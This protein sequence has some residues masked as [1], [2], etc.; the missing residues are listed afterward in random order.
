MKS[1]NAI[2]LQFQNKFIYG[3]KYR[4]FIYNVSGCFPNTIIRIPQT[5]RLPAHDIRAILHETEKMIAF[6]DNSH[7]TQYKISITHVETTKTRY[8]PVFTEPTAT[9]G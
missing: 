5:N 2:P 4:S 3:S 8:A 9:S 7:V 1:F 6:A